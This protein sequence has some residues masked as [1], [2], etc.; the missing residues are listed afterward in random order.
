[1]KKIGERAWMTSGLIWW[2]ARLMGMSAVA[3]SIK[4]QFDHALS[5]EIK[6]AEE[7]GRLKR[8]KAGGKWI[9]EWSDEIEMR[10][11][12]ERDPEACWSENWDGIWRL[13]SFD[14]P[15]KKTKTRRRLLRSL[16]VL[17][18]GKLQDSL[19][20]CPRRTQGVEDLLQSIDIPASELSFFEAKSLFGRDEDEIIFCSWP[21][22]QIGEN[23]ANYL[24][25]I[26]I[27]EK[28]M[29]ETLDVETAGKF[30]QKEAEC[31]LNAIDQDPFLPRPFD[32]E[33]NDG[34]DAW[35]ARQ[36]FIHIILKK[37]G[38]AHS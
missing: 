37:A 14:L 21:W 36:E 29:D 35:K 17:G 34:P 31:W 2:T 33:G 6:E 30:I 19:W 20:I 8:S 4:Q 18:F 5:E 13:F 24:Q 38:V 25:E 23:Y 7:K 26:A 32:P 9:W 28:Q 1:M 11:R 10:M 27:M 3:A 12:G 16:K 15:A 22:D